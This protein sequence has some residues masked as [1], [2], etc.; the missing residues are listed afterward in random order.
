MKKVLVL[1]ALT[2]AMSS[3]YAANVQIYGSVDTGIQIVHNKN[4]DTNV[5]MEPVLVGVSSLPKISV[6]AIP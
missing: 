2:L 6:T 3:V 4:G 1:S 5:S